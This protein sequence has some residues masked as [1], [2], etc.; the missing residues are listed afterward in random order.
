MF[1]IVKKVVK[2]GELGIYPFQYNLPSEISFPESFW[3]DVRRIFDD[4]K[5]DGRERVISLFWA[6]GELIVTPVTEGNEESVVARD[7]IQVKYLP[8]PFKGDYF[9]REIWLKGKVYSRKDVF[10]KNIPQKIVLQY[11]CN[12]HTHPISA[13]GT[14]SFFSSQDI[15]TYISSKGT[16]TMLVTDCLWVLFRTSDT[17]VPGNFGEESVTLEYLRDVCK[18][19]VYRGDFGKKVERL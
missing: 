9:R 13:S 18:F 14:Y 19:V 17:I 11:L 8:H 1:N 16:F 5:G 7:S 15:D 2:L 6:D 12:I 10:K 4:T 3:K